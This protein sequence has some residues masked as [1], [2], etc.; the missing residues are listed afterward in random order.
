MPDPTRDG[1]PVPSRLEFLGGFES[2]YMPRHDVDVLES[3]GHLE[4]RNADLRLAADLGL[5]RVR[6][7]VRWH[8]VEETRGRFD[9]AD[10]D[11]AFEALTAVGLQ[12][13]VDLL[14]HTSYP[15]WLT[16]GF[17]DR[18][19]SPA[20]LRFV[21]AFLRRYP[22]VQEVTLHNEPFTNCFLGGHEGFWPPHL[23]G[24]DGFLACLRQVVPSLAEASRMLR[25]LAPHARHVHVDT[26]ERAVGLD[27][28]GERKAAVCNDRRFIVLDLLLG[29]VADE[30]RPFVRQL[31]EAGGEDLLTSQ[32]GYVDV[33]G[34]DYYA[35]QEWSYDGGSG[36]QPSR[37]PAGLASLILEYG[38][39]YGLPMLLTETNLRGAASDRVTWLKHTLEQCEI[40][41][42]QG[43][44][45]TGYCWYGV[46]DSVDWNSLC[47]RHD[48]C[49]DPVG[50]FWIDQHHDRKE[51]VMSEAYRRAAAG[52]AAAE[53]P[54]YRFTPQVAAHLLHLLPLMDHYDWRDPRPEDTAMID[55]GIVRTLKRMQEAA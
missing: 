55:N 25:E 50:V 9:W 28:W 2:T 18:D 1:C 54:A 40:A 37:R 36:H 7:P 16:G 30:R 12:P 42:S 46:V 11:R 10:T 29:R 3:S 45:L 21:E 43:A 38:E 6:Y 34:L 14:H 4:R 53:L 35:H 39:R 8:R 52:A 33:L 32:P 51:S 49:I 23:N 48:G 20:Y 22:W 47:R 44:D 5:R 31:L 24:L 26:C 19:F 13:I 17:A 27:S 41:R 15:R